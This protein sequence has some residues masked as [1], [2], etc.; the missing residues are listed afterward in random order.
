MTGAREVLITG[1]SGFVGARLASVLSLRGYRV[2]GLDVALPARSADVERAGF[3]AFWQCDLTRERV[4]SAASGRRFDVIVHL[5]ARSP[6]QCSRADLFALNVG[7]TSALLEHFASSNAHLVFFSTGLVYGDKLAPFAESMPC[8]AVDAFGQS[9]LAAEAVLRAFSN[10]TD[11]PLT[12]FR[13]SLLYGHGAPRRNFVRCLFRALKTGEPFPMSSGEQLRDFLHVDDATEAV[14]AAIERRVVGTWNLA[15]GEGR[16]LR[17]VAES[18]ARIAQR[19]DLLHVGELPYRHDE[20]FDCRLDPSGL[21]RR[22]GFRAAIKLEEGLERMW[23]E[24]V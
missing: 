10:K 8:L 9:K 18:A 2:T 12:V 24:M 1:G 14:A 23:A 13:P 6:E 4:P 19:L 7:G 16:S 3:S 21:E 17:Q 22:M 11:M 5:A 15:S 20:M